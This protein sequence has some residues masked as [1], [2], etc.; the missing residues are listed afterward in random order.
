MQHTAGT[1][2]LSLQVPAVLGE[3]VKA[4]MYLLSQVPTYRLVY[5][6]VMTMGMA[7]SNTYWS[8]T[9]LPLSAVMS[10]YITPAS[11]YCKQER[12]G[13]IMIYS[14]VFWGGGG[15]APYICQ[16]TAKAHLI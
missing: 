9:I 16:T 1:Q 13:P 2:Y 10:W 11:G 12:Y 15:L 14:R 5:L 8:P 3:I 7:V 4:S 6:R